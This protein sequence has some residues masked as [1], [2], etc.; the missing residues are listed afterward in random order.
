MVGSLADAHGVALSGLAIAVS[1][2]VS[3]GQ[4]RSSS[5]QFERTMSRSSDQFEHTMRH[6]IYSDIVNGMASDSVGVQVGFRSAGLASTYRTPP[7][8]TTL[9]VG[10]VCGKCGSNVGSLHRG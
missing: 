2:L 6:N 3:Y 7:T 8:M 4:L 5:D 9:R 1:I 10:A